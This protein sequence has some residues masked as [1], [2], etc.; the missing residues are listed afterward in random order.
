[1][2]KGHVLKMITEMQ[3]YKLPGA[4]S[5]KSDENYGAPPTYYGALAANTNPPPQAMIH[6]VD[7]VINQEVMV[8]AFLTEKSLAFNMAE[9]IIDMARGLSKDP[10]TLTKLHLFRKTLTLSKPCKQHCLL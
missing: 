10:Q 7:R 6:A 9:P 4:A 1:M 2:G 3:C 5:A 8:T